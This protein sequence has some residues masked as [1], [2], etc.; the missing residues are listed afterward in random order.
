MDSSVAVSTFSRGNSLS[1]EASPSVWQEP[2]P[3]PAPGDLM[4]P[5][6]WQMKGKRVQWPTWMLVWLIGASIIRPLIL[7]RHWNFRKV[8]QGLALQLAFF[9]LKAPAHLQTWIHFCRWIHNGYAF[10]SKT[11]RLWMLISQHSITAYHYS[12][13]VCKAYFTFWL[14]S[15][16]VFLWCL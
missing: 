15:I 16:V 14:N 3:L 5:A 4:T 7:R 12:I 8:G 11:G 6:L 2:N 1:R 13:T 10:L 9:Q